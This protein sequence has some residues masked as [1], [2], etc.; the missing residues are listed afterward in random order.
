MSG[1]CN[2]FIC[3]SL[4]CKRIFIFKTVSFFFNISNY[5]PSNWPT[6]FNFQQLECKKIHLTFNPFNVRILMVT[7]EQFVIFFFQPCESIS[8][9]WNY[10]RLPFL[11]FT[12][13]PKTSSESQW[14]FKPNCW[15]I[16]RITKLILINSLTHLSREKKRTWA[17]TVKAQMYK[18]C[19]SFFFLVFFSVFVSRC[20]HMSK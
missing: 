13:A 17:K 9:I 5:M 7:F 6:S 3:L 1:C 19:V 12:W 2:V 18:R 14:C 15:K 16:P 11:L 4:N 10:L 8:R 20:N